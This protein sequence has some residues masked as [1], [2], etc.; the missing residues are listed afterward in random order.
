MPMRPSGGNWKDFFAAATKG[1]VELVRFHLDN[2]VD[3]DYQHPEFMTTALIEASTFGQLE[4][5]RTLLAHGADAKLRSIM[6]G[7]TA[8]EAAS[9]SGHRQVVEVLAQHLGVPMPALPEPDTSSEPKSA[10]KRVLSLF[11]VS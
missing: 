5:V 6:D 11:G 3:A 8:L 1:D 7:W 10:M 9:K 4:V 2:G